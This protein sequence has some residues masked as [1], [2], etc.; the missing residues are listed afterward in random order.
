[1]KNNFTCVLMLL[2][3]LSLNINAQNP[4][5]TDE[6]AFS[7]I[8]LSDPQ[9]YTKFSYN[10]PIFDLMVEWINKETENLNIKAVVCTGDLVERNNYP[11]SDIRVGTQGANGNQ[12]SIE[13][14]K[15]ISSAFARLDNKLPYITSLGNHDYGYVSAENRQTKFNEY[16][17]SAR[18]NKIKHHVVSYY[19][20]EAGEATLENSAYEFIESG[21]DKILII[22]SE[23]HPR[24]EVLE[25]A[26][27]LVNSDKYKDHFVIFMTHSY[28][29]TN[30]VRINKENYQIKNPNY[31]EDIWNKLIYPSKNISLVLCGHAAE[32]G[33]NFERNVGY[34]N[35]KNIA[36]KD[37][38]QI[39]FNAQALGGGWHGNGGDGWLRILEFMPDGQTINIKTFSPFFAI[40]PT[41]K[42]HAWRK[43][44]YDE[45]SITIR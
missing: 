21:W 13:Q 23:F 36:D 16:F 1:M 5:L 38:H 34:R 4:K 31:G 22:T 8:M 37:V 17:D 42:K 14:W 39:M 41:S 25:W 28:L 18:N 44:S 24:D 6:N 43:E 32:P 2:L 27:N 15:Y 10:Q 35:D 3:L 12:T 33:E 9:S 19:P 26:A 40:S 20:N 30:D 7:M 29:S 45:Y 11:L